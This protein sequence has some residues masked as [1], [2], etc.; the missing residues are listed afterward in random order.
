MIQAQIEERKKEAEELKR[1][2]EYAKKREALDQ[3]RK[4]KEEQKFAEK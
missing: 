4:D 2:E 3:L 1:V